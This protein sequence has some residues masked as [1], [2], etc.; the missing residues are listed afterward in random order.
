METKKQYLKFLNSL[1]RQFFKTTKCHQKFA[2]KKRKIFRTHY[3]NVQGTTFQRRIKKNIPQF[4]GYHCK[5]K[6]NFSSEFLGVF[7]IT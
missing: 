4:S 6:K 5:I 1:L 3:Y 7:S 2:M